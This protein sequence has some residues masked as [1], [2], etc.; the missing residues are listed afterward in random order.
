MSKQTKELVRKFYEAFDASDIATLETLVTPDF[1]QYV[2]SDP[3]PVRGLEAMKSNMGS[4]RGGHNNTHTIQDI[5]AEGD[6]VVVRMVMQGTVAQPLLNNPSTVG[7][8]W[9]I[10]VCTIFR[11]ANGKIAERW[12]NVDLMGRLEQTGALPGA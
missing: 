7:K 12:I 8:P 3:N 11:I 5:F 9:K 4:L 1:V 10:Q 6:K 2:N